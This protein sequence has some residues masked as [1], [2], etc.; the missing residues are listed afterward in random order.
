MRLNLLLSVILV[1]VWKCPGD[2]ITFLV[3]KPP[4]C[5]GTW[6]EVGRSHLPLFAPVQ[7]RLRTPGL[8]WRLP[9]E[10]RHLMSQVCRRTVGDRR[11]SWW[12]L[13]AWEGESSPADSQPST[14]CAS[15]IGAAQECGI[16]VRG[17]NR[18]SWS[19]AKEAQNS[20][21]LSPSY[22]PSAG[23]L[24]NGVVCSCLFSLGGGK[25]FKCVRKPSALAV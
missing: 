16:A 18:R 7:F 12:P 3:L 23:G 10:S 5:L 22:P 1:Y 24:G 9:D 14:V 15:G 19:K 2:S 13:R 6:H 21:C 20:V 17:A 4:P 8:A 11:A 25:S